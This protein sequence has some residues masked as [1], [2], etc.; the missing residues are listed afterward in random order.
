MRVREGEREREREGGGG[1]RIVRG[2][3]ERESVD[4]SYI[5]VHTHSHTYA[6]THTHTHTLQFLEAFQMTQ[7]FENFI[8]QREN[9]NKAAT[10]SESLF[11]RKIPDL[12]LGCQEIEM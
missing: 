4:C 3:W 12:S 11:E 10:V 9:P 8:E 6:H 1:G 5:H 2:W 7:M